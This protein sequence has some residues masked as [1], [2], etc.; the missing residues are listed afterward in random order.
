MIGSLIK[1]VFAFLDLQLDEAIGLQGRGQLAL[2]EDFRALVSIMGRLEALIVVVGHLQFEVEPCF[3]HNQRVWFG[4]VQ[5]R[6]YGVI[7]SI[8][9][10]GRYIARIDGYLIAFVPRDVFSVF[11]LGIFQRSCLGTARSVSMR[12]SFEV[13]SCVILSRQS[14]FSR[15]HQQSRRLRRYL[16]MQR[17]TCAYEVFYPHRQFN[18]R[19]VQF[20]LLPVI[21]IFGAA[22]TSCAELSTRHIVFD[23]II[24]SDL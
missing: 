1:G 9:A 10:Q 16:R 6:S 17:V 4:S 5:M 21:L 2:G 20:G 14:W 3:L 22:G 8:F 24:V 11:L 13:A 15:C 12:E 7:V 19:A 23:F 18:T